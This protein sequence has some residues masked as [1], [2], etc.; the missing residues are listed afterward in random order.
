MKKEDLFKDYNEQRIKKAEDY[1]EENYQMFVAS[2]NIVPTMREDVFSRYFL[3]RM[4]GEVEDPK[5]RYKWLVASL[6]PASPV[7]IIDESGK[8]LF[9]VPPLLQSGKLNP[10][11]ENGESLHGAYK[12]LE[13][14]QGNLL[15]NPTGYMRNQI[16]EAYNHLIEG[17]NLTEER[18]LW[19]MILTRYGRL[20]PTGTEDK[21]KEIVSKV[22]EDNDDTVL[23]YDYD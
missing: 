12:G 5:W 8:E 9:K 2:P 18:E 22:T 1:A 16:N 14:R 6:T 13:L 20:K 17:F 15:H 7:S 4:L 19:R 21:D 3:P 23:E 11:K 10:K